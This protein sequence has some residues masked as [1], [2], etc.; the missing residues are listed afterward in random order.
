MS[1]VSV[2]EAW[3]KFQSLSESDQRLLFAFLKGYL[4]EELFVKTMNGF[5]ESCD[6]TK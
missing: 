3:E 1:N 5:F 2:K 6:D 4:G